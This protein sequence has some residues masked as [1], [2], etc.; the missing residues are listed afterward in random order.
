MEVSKDREFKLKKR[1]KITRNKKPI[2]LIATEGKNKTET[3]YFRN[4]KNKYN[5]NIVFCKGNDTD[6]ISMIEVLNKEVKKLTEKEDIA[7][8]IFDS[9]VSVSKNIQI[10]KAKNKINNKKIKLIMSSPCIEIWFLNH[11]QYST[12]CYNS[13]DEVI[14]ELKKYIKSYNKGKDIFEDINGKIHSAIDNSKN[15]EKYHLELGRASHTIEC[16]PST[17]VYKVVEEIMKYK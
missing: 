12:R 1:G 14:K 16:N 13:N 2:L 9:D 3:I 15:M 6:P 10:S 17:D 7:F 5:C 11:F 8:C 4:F